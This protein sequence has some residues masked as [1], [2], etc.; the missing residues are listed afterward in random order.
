VEAGETP[1]GDD[2]GG[3]PNGSATGIGV[4]YLLAATPSLALRGDGFATVIGEQQP[5][6]RPSTDYDTS[7]RLYFEPLTL[8]DVLNVH[9]KRSDLKGDRPVAPESPG[10]KLA[11]PLLRWLATPGG[12]ATGTRLWAPHLKSIDQARSRERSRRSCAGLGESASPANGLAEP[13]TKQGGGGR[14]WLPR[15]SVRRQLRAGRPRM[16]WSR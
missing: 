4:R 3:G 11:L 12:V 14:P 9:R 5:G 16:E 13:L 7:D 6:N 2:L 8:E 15:L 1:Q 10:F